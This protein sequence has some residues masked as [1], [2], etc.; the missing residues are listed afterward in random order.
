MMLDPTS[1][2]NAAFAIDAESPADSDW[3]LSL[4]VIGA[5]E[6]GTLN[7]F[8][9]RRGAITG[10][11]A[12]RPVTIETGWRSRRSAPIT[13][14]CVLELAVDGERGELVLPLRLL[15]AI[16]ALLPAARSATDLRSEH[17]AI[18]LELILTEAL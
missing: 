9:R 10:R 7:A 13:D 6:V 4:P 5:D 18:V 11:L 3:L 2:S 12:G 14:P 1:I 16:T 8:Y 15:E 17:A